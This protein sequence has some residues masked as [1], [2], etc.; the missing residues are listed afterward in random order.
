MDIVA[1]T[2]TE[3][4]GWYAYAWAA[5][6]FMV[7][8]VAT[9][10]PQL[11]QSYARQNA[12]LADDHT[13][14][15][16]TPPVPFPGDP[17]VPTDP[18]IPPNSSLSTSVPWF[19]RFNDVQLFESSADTVHVM[20]DHKAKPTQPTCVIKFFGIYID[21]ASFPLY[22]FS[23][24]VLLQVVV[25]ISMS[26]AAD[27]GRF[28]KQLLLFFGIA[29][30]LTT[31][32]FVFITPKRYYLGSFLAIVS[33]AAFGAATVCGN[34]YLPVLAAGMKNGTTS[35]EPSEPGTPSDTSKP[36]SRSENTRNE[37]TPLLSATGADYETG[38]SS[39]T[40]EVVKI[41]HR[42]NVSAR[43]SGTGVALGY[44]AGFIVQI[45]SIYL[46][47]STG[48]TTWSLR[49]ALL[50]VGVWWLVFQI[51]VFLWLKPRPG[52]PLPI[53]TDP[54][55]HPW[56]A[57]L[58]RVTNGGWSYVT[59]GWKTL[60]VTF[61]EARQMKDVALFLVGWFLVSDGIT[62][63]NS[64]AVLFAQGELRMSPANLAVMGMLVVISGIS[65]A[66]LTPLIGG[67]RASPI[68]SIVVVV[69]LAAAVP[70]YGILGFFFTNIGL[71][72]P[73]ELYVLAVWYGF[74]LGGLNTVCRSTFSMLIPR[75]KEAVFFSLFS[76]TDKGS[77]VL[78]PLLVGLIVDK[79]HNL[80][81][82]FYLLL[83]LLI[84]PIGLF[85]MIDMER[86]RKEAEYLETVEE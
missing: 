81:H 67:T 73:W 4:Y 26:G 85:L 74:A 21:T 50:I 64:T 47:I 40:A 6:P 18:G 61:K 65:G 36:P 35:E 9:Y 76:V 3:L 17:G 34:A 11:L 39:D 69:S 19:L 79:T 60:L 31:G 70:A 24:S 48:S 23:L 82:A 52:P 25:V 57:T 59:Y 22:T 86:G 27:R 58:D 46:V 42:A 12:V 84:T 33:N 32:L 38:E 75:G 83:V 51:P 37:N 45:I 78:G 49:L 66:K 7:V 1:T 80:R 54:Q 44:L 43:I 62:T 13:Q 29:G 15:C 20:K 68:K 14:P 28:R 63:I 41:D 72:N 55:N 77:S 53:K 16:D 5:E 10:I 8:A 30:A 71:K 2:Q 56:T